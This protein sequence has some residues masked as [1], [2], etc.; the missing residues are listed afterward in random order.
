MDVSFVYYNKLCFDEYYRFTIDFKD[1][2]V[3]GQIIFS[4]SNDYYINNITC[5]IIHKITTNRHVLELSKLANEINRLKQY[6]IPNFVWIHYNDIRLFNHY[7]FPLLKTK[8]WADHSISEI[9]TNTYSYYDATEKKLKSFKFHNLY[10]EIFASRFYYSAPR[11]EGSIRSY[12]LT[13]DGNKLKKEIIFNDDRQAR[14][15]Y[16]Q[17]NYISSWDPVDKN[18]SNQIRDGLTII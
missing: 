4:K 9:Y 5:Y 11:E 18:L 8:L 13:L 2:D 1:Q 14:N 6:R 16:H 7:Q 17:L 10:N 15:V 3:V 12:R